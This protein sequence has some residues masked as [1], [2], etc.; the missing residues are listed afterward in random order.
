MLW[1]FVTMSLQ[2]GKLNSLTGFYSMRLKVKTTSKEENH[3]CSE[4]LKGKKSHLGRLVHLM[5]YLLLNMPI[6]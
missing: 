5:R 4:G 3:N 2:S 6:K 1:R